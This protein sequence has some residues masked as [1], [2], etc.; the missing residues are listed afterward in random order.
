MLIGWLHSK[1]R[2][3]LLPLLWDNWPSGNQ[4]CAG[5]VCMS[6]TT[7]PPD[8]QTC[9][10]PAWG[11]GATETGPWAS[12]HPDACGEQ[13][14]A[15]RSWVSKHAASC[16]AGP[17]H[18]SSLSGAVAAGRQQCP[19]QPP[20]LPG[21]PGAGSAKGAMMEM[22]ETTRLAAA[23]GASAC[24]DSSMGMPCQQPAPS[25]PQPDTAGALQGA[26]AS[27]GRNS[28]ARLLLRASSA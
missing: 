5:A 16:P 2:V 15:L 9:S 28:P 3:L 21:C 14:S 27:P 18:S 25:A 26:A 12:L 24:G 17:S 4:L 23:R 8:S 13:P 22:S 7:S 6:C 20:P 10:A 1:C 19:G 11:R